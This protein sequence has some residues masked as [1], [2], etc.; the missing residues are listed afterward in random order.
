MIPLDHDHFH[1][2]RTASKSVRTLSSYDATDRHVRLETS[3]FFCWRFTTYTRYIIFTSNQPTR[4]SSTEKEIKMESLKEE[5]Q[6][7]RAMRE[8][9][10]LNKIIAEQKLK[11]LLWVKKQEMA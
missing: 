7:I 6:I 5:R 2:K 11:H 9:A 4:F 10:E 1:I 8:T 3:L